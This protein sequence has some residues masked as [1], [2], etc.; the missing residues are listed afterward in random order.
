MIIKTPVRDADSAILRKQRN[1]TGELFLNRWLAMDISRLHL[2]RPSKSSSYEVGFVVLTTVSTK[3]AVIPLMMEAVRPSENVC[4][5]PDY[6][7]LQ[8]SRQPSSR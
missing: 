7:A 8:P 4:K 6:T 3:T 2:C 1:C 5:L